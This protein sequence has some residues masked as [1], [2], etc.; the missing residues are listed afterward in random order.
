MHCRNCNAPNPPG[1]T[2]CHACRMPGDFGAAPA[3]EARVV[4]APTH[5]CGNCAADVPDIAAHCPRCRWPQP[6]AVL[7]PPRAVEV[8]LPRRLAV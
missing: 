1:A 7:R 2:R 3:P 4:P 8:C 6:A 5:A